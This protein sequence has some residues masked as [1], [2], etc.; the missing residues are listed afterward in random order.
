MT[1]ERAPLRPSSVLPSV[2]TTGNLLCGLLAVIMA[3][4]ER[5]AFAA[6]LV[7]LGLVF[8][9]L[10]G[11]MARWLGIATDFGIEYDSLADVITFGLAPAFLWIQVMLTPWAHGGW[12]SG[13]LFVVGAALRL[14]RFNIQS[15]ESKPTGF[16]QGLPSPGAAGT[17]AGLT[18]LVTHIGVPQAPW[19]SWAALLLPPALALLMISTI[20]YRH[21]K[22]V[23]RDAMRISWFIGGFAAFLALILIAPH[24]TLAL[25]FGGYALSGPLG[26]LWPRGSS[27][28]KEV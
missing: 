25:A 17:L 7:F 21:L 27:P 16:F 4:Q 23:P 18:L 19:V 11:Q 5:Y 9:A 15:N 1:D 26:L 20:P 10:D 3:A 8:D 6:S 12:L 24:W 22:H 28:S 2:L 14:A 13:F